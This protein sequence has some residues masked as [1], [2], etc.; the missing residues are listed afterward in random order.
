MILHRQINQQRNS[1]Q[2][3]YPFNRRAVLLIEM[4][5]ILPVLII[6]LVLAIDISRFLIVTMALNNA[7]N[8]GVV[9]GS[10][11]ALNLT[12]QSAWNDQIQNAIS[13]SMAQYSWFDNSKLSVNIPVPLSA[14][15]MIDANGFRSIEVHITY[16]AD[17][18]IPWQGISSPGLVTLK[19]RSDQVR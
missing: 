1:Q 15:G 14:N 10:N 9:A 4:A 8:Q 16:Q 12:S 13:N 3:K 6:V 5:F 18:V 7:A 17:Y 2:K 11:H 19:L